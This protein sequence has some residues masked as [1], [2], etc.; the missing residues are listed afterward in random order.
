MLVFDE[1]ALIDSL[2]RI[3]VEKCDDVSSVEEAREIIIKSGALTRDD[4]EEIARDNSGVNTERQHDVCVNMVYQFLCAIYDFVEFGIYNLVVANKKMGELR[5][6]SYELTYISQ[7]PDYEKICKTG[8]SEFS[9]AR[10]FTPSKGYVGILSSEIARDNLLNQ[11]AYSFTVEYIKYWDNV[12]AGYKRVSAR[13]QRVRY[14]I[15][16]ITSVS[17]GNS[18]FG[19]A[20]MIALSG[21]GR[22]LTYAMQE[23]TTLT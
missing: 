7:R 23:Q 19:S 12:L 4:C 9:C 1:S 18:Y 2:A 15:D 6:L 13:I 5:S 8:V 16:S 3:M 14:L 11:Q 10:G 21:Y 20:A 17:T 22:G